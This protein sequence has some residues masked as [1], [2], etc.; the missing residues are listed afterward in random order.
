MDILNVLAEITIYS[1]VVFTVIMLLK[2]C[3]GSKMSPFLHYAVWA[4]LIVRLLMPVTVTSPFHF[5]VLPEES[6]IPVVSEQTAL[7]PSQP[8]E[9]T[10]AYTTDTEPATIQGSSSAAE[11]AVQ[12][13]TVQSTPA[14][15]KK[16]TAL[17]WQQ[18]AIIVWLVGVGVCSVYIAAVFFSLRRRLKRNSAPPSEKL[19]MLFEET[20]AQMGIKGNIR[21]IC[22]YEY[23]TPALMFPRTVIM[24]LDALA[25]MDDEQ[26]KYA[27]R[28]E[29]THFRRGDHITSIFLSL[30]NAVYW[31][32]PLVWLAF[33]QMR[34]DMETACD[35]ELVKRIGDK[36]KSRYAALIVSLFAQP[37]YRQVVLGMAQADVRK[38]AEK[39][40]RG[41]FMKSKSQRSVKWISALLVLVMIVA[42]FTTAC[43]PTP[44]APVVVNKG[45]GKLEDEIN[46][47]P[48]PTEKYKAPA[49]YK[50]E[51]QSFYDGMLSVSFDMQVETPDVNAYPVYTVQDADLTQQ[52]VNRIVSALMQDKPLKYYD[53]RDTKQ[54]ITEKFLL[55]EQ[56]KAFRCKK[57]QAPL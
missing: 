6:T 22:M 31:F 21:L 49:Q 41:I 5:F 52:Q 18:I 56:E 2:K 16:Q 8:S 30:L 51:P 25:A 38:V 15:V 55:P 54:E 11:I 29:L 1:G 42:C 13:E 47:T 37:K 44:E 23:G 36:E 27:L 35:G 34:M 33:R 32:N 3:L 48:A 43:Q 7:D 53:E 17:S 9:V 45:D 46:A 40:V 26:T 4:V 28:H 10:P 50:Q 14:I 57:W 19:Q 24:P 20:K 39:R 12:N